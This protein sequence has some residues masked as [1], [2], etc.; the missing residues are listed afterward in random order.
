MANELSLT[1]S[2]VFTGKPNSEGPAGFSIDEVTYAM[3]QTGKYYTR[4]T[5]SIG[6]SAA[7]AVAVSADIGTQGF[8]M[9]WNLNANTGVVKLGLSGQTGSAML[10]KIL[11]GDEAPAIFRANA[12]AYAIASDAAV[13][14]E[15]L[16]I[17][18]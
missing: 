8:W 13:N 6:T 7:E 12:P 14:I 5:Q 3:D 18:L 15:F 17:E 10:I 9:V 1:V 16:C 11:P 4:G 2:F